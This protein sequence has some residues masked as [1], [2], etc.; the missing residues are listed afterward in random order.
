[1]FVKAATAQGVFQPFEVAQV[2]HFA[3]EVRGG[4]FAVGAPTDHVELVTGRPPENFESTARRYIQN[5]GLI[6]P[7][8]GAGGTLGALWLMMKT[9]LSH[10]PDL[11]HWQ[12]ERGYSVL[13]DP[14]LA[15]DSDEWRRA[16]HQRRLAL[17][18]PSER[19][20]AVAPS[21][22]ARTPMSA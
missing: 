5:P 7:G 18:E 16:A 20:A 4:T 11:D 21:R 3:E 6:A 8:F 13:R 10:S 1:M 9:V 2:R 14:V 12:S 19:P 17:L 22:L 15:H